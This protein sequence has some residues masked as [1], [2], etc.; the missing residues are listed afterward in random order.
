MVMMMLLCVLEVHVQSSL[1]ICDARTGSNLLG[2][3][4]G[5]DL[6]I[7]KDELMEAVKHHH[8]EEYL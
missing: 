4:L 5:L 3:S 6:V 8:F 7:N 1:I 2:M